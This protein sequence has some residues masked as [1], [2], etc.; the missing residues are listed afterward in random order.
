[1]NNIVSQFV[2]GIESYEDETLRDEENHQNH[3]YDE[4][5]QQTVDDSQLD[6]DQHEWNVSS[7]DFQCSTNYPH[8]VDRVVPR[9]L[10]VKHFA[11]LPLTNKINII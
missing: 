9:F 1:M 7:F 10:S 6:V 5:N 4:E 8:F 3:D 2:K 11:I